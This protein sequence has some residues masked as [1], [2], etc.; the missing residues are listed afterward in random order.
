MLVA[1]EDSSEGAVVKRKGRFQ[2]TSADLSPKEP[3]SYFFNPVQGGTSPS[4]LGVTAASLL[5]TLQCILQQNTMQREE[6]V[7]LIKFTER[8]SVNP[9][10]LSEAGTNDLPQMPA[11]SVRERELQSMVIQL[12]KSIGSLVE[13][14]QRKKMKNVQLE[15]KLNR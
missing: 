8:G 5:P 13:E 10:D 15:K 3:T 12:Q 11:N 4:N 7:K 9:T 14:L 1:G 6:I 2:V